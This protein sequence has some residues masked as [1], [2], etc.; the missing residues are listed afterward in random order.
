MP[1]QGSN[2]LEDLLSTSLSSNNSDIIAD[3]ESSLDIEETEL[4][5]LPQTQNIHSD[6]DNNSQV[7]EGNQ[8]SVHPPNDTKAVSSGINMNQRKQKRE[9]KTG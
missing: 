2:N 7:V 4:P 6:E 9:R 3:N 8:V 5:D 1:W